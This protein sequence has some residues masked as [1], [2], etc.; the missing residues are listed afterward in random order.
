LSGHDVEAEFIRELVAPFGPVAVRRM[1]GARIDRN[2]RSAARGGGRQ[3][4]G[5]Q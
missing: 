2:R 5:R 4:Y 3:C 1:F